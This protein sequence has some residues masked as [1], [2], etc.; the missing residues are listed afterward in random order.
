MGDRP[1]FQ[2]HGF[3]FG[4]VKHLWI[5][6]ALLLLPAPAFAQAVDPETCAGCH[7]ESVASYQASIHGKKGHPKS[8]ASALGCASCHANSAEHAKA[9][10]GRGAGGIGN[11]SPRNKTMTAAQK[12]AVC[13]SCHADN[14]HLAFWDSGRHRKNDVTC[15][16]CHTAHGS[17]T[18]LLRVE[19][20]AISPYVNTSQLPQQEVCFTCHRDVRAQVMRPSHHPIQEGKIKC[21]SC[22]NPHGA[23]SPAMLNHESINAQCTSCHADKRGPFM[24]DHPPVEENCLNCHSPHGSRSAKLLKE[25]VPNI[26]QDCHDASQHPGTAYDLT[27][28]FRG[29]S[30]GGTIN[31][32]F[33]ARSCMNCHN[34]VHGS[35]VPGGRGRRLVR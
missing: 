21:S 33:V 9:G 17:Q 10:G 6:A 12:D 22:H 23:L 5:W 11:P 25:K 16:N 4:W 2:P 32:R 24:F 18:A 14:R 8:P 26:C 28:S 1:R 34:E 13:Q 27:D 7:A 20:P 31:S 19:N 3:S 35:N 15:A 30:L 29:P